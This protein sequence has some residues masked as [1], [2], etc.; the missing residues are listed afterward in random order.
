[1]TPEEKLE[2][3]NEQRSAY[4]SFVRA[5]RKCVK[6]GIRFHTVL[7]KIYFL[8]GKHI[9]KI[10]DDPHESDSVCLQEFN[11]PS[12]FDWGFSGWAD[13]THYAKIK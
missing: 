5:H 10:H 11:A 2:L 3:T 4:K 8:N 7:E 9:K 12:V 1:M 6:V 13:D